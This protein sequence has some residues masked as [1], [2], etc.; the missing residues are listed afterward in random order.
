MFVS[1]LIQLEVWSLERQ[2]REILTVESRNT[3][4]D[5]LL[6]RLCQTVQFGISFVIH[7]LLSLQSYSS[8]SS[9]MALHWLSRQCLQAFVSPL[10]GSERISGPSYVEERT[11]ESSELLLDKFEYSGEVA[12]AS[13]TSNQS[14]VIFILCHIQTRV[15]R[16]HFGDVAL[17][18]LV[19][20]TTAWT[21]CWLTPHINMHV[22]YKSLS[23]SW[24]HEG[25]IKP[26][27]SS[28]IDIDSL[29]IPRQ[30]LQVLHQ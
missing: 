1:I 3:A 13:A 6:S 7:L 30:C 23:K 18:T 29:R 12:P 25:G 5:T 8:S 10:S 17:E 24:T 16:T 27:P 19:R 2:G 9:V 26:V 11:L 22:F 14:R 20:T 28:S 21:I 4:D 15:D